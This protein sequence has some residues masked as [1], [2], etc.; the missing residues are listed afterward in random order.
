MTPDQVL[1]EEQERIEKII[2]SE[3]RITQSRR[4]RED[5]PNLPIDTNVR[6]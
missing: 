2:E 6:I 1:V 3:E 4:Q 5:I